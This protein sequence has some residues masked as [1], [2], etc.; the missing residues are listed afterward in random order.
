MHYTEA[1]G[2]NLDY[3]WFAVDYVGQ[4]TTAVAP[5]DKVST[6]AALYG[7]GYSINISRSNETGDFA[8]VSFSA[9]TDGLSNTVAF[10]ELI[11]TASDP[12]KYGKS[13]LGTDPPAQSDQRGFIQVAPLFT[14]YYEPNTIQP[15]EIGNALNCHPLTP[16]APGIPSLPQAGVNPAR[17]QRLSARSYHTGGVNAAFGDASVSFVS[18]NTERTVWRQLGDAADGSAASL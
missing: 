15:D 14:T 13:P 16:R 17:S 3:G 2:G 9:A 7:C 12:E 6:C 10:S 5:Y 8:R 11:Q 4:P 1:Q 18:D